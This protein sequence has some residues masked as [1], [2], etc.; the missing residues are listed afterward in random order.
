MVGKVLAR[1]MAKRRRSTTKLIDKYRSSEA[2]T[3]AVMSKS[4]PE[5]ISQQNYTSCAPG[6]ADESGGLGIS[7][8]QQQM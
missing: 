8:Q 6:I 3:K 4:D 2:C 1:K 5:S 7:I